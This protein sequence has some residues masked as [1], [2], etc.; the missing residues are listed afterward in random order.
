MNIGEVIPEIAALGGVLK[1]LIYE[2][3]KTDRDG[4]IL[5]R[6]GGSLHALQAA[7]AP[8]W[9][10]RTGG[11]VGACTLFFQCRALRPGEVVR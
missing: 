9:V 3:E 1:P 11:R 8:P 5:Q 4:E 10:I 6:V 2:K 7:G